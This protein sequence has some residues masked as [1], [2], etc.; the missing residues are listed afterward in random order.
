MSEPTA[1][2][3]QLKISE[4]QLNC[5]LKSKQA[6]TEI[7]ITTGEDGLE[8]NP[9]NK[10]SQLMAE[11]LY[12]CHHQSQNVF[13][14]DYDTKKQELFFAYIL[15]HGGMYHANAVLSVVKQATTFQDQH[16]QNYAL[17]F[18]ST[19]YDF[20]TGFAFENSKT[21]S[22]LQEC[23][24]EL[25]KDYIA[26][27]W[28]YYDKKLDCFPE[29]AIAIRKRYYFYKPIITAYKKYLKVVEL[30][31]KPEKLKLATAQNPYHLFDFLYAWDG[32][33]YDLL[34][35]M[36]Q[37]KELIH[38]DPLTL[39]KVGAVYADKNY[40]YQCNLDNT[41]NNAYLPK[42][43]IDGASYQL[44]GGNSMEYVYTQDKNHIYFK[45]RVVP[46][47][48]IK[49]F[50][51]IDFAFGK[52]KS[53]VYYQDQ[54][55]PIDPANFLIDK[56]GFIRDQNNIFHYGVKIEMHAPTFKVVQYESDLNPF[57]GVFV[58]L[59]KNASYQF[60]TVHKTFYQL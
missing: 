28:S 43:G 56:H 17:I 38:A 49:T 27:V 31:E 59:D 6:A 25:L 15:N 4:D 20:Y 42:P 40:V 9:K 3:I 52:D 30:Q 55:I 53:R 14:F 12:S 34:Y 45:E 44:V 5:F 51:Y 13:L 26:K 8:T 57:M 50:K 7:F 18:S 22:Q 41:V 54:I 36:S 35:G 2:A 11:M 10:V 16:T 29:P 19:S 47:A 58:L 21:I 60:D 37:P 1:I 48:D 23:P 46:Q 24:D 33:V 32:K 39:R